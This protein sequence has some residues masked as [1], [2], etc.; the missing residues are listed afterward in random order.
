MVVPLHI[1]IEHPSTVWLLGVAV[2]AFVAGLAVNLYRSNAASETPDA[3]VDAVE[4]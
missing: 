1:G 3:D 2:V 4:E